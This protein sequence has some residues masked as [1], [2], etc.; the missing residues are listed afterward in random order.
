MYSWKIIRTVCS[1]LLLLP[2]V[3]VTYIISRNT[4][5]TL[6][7]SPLAWTREINAYAASDSTQALPEKPVVVVGGQRVKLWFGLADVLS[8]RPVIMR[9]LGDAIVEDITFHYARLIGFYRPDTVV[10]LPSASEFFIRDSKSAQ[11]LLE[12][13]VALV[14]QDAKHGVTR[15]F[16]VFTPIKTP[17]RPQSN[18][19]IDQSVALLKIWASTRNG[20]E[21]LDANSLLTDTEG[22]PLARYFRGDGTNLNEHGYLRLAVLLQQQLEADAIPVPQV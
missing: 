2:L 14:E 15:K 10:L 17:G 3:H 19:T 7:S 4:L 13:V 20:T 11:D 6:D 1:I 12:A 22:T 18:I 5:E 9:G 21:V 16:Y 8:P